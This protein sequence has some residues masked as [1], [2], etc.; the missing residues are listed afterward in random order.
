ML[1]TADDIKKE[2]DRIEYVIKPYDIVFINTSASGYYGKDDYLLKGCG[3][4]KEATIFL[5]RSRCTSFN[6]D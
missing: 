5:F 1:V 3:I 4:G 6:W 2:L